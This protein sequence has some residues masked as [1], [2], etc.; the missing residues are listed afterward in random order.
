VQTDCASGLFCADGVCCN[1]ACTGT[2]QACSAA[3][4]GQGVDGVCGAVKAGDDPHNQCPASPAST[5]A[6]MGGCDGAGACAPWPDGTV[7]ST[8]KCANSTTQYNPRTCIGGTCSN[9]AVPQTACAPDACVGGASGACVT[10]CGTTPFTDTNC[11]I[12]NYCDGTGIGACKPKLTT[13]ACTNNDEC[14]S[15][16]CLGGACCASMCMFPGTPCGALFC[17]MT[18]G[19][20][21]YA[22]ALTNCGMGTCMS[23]KLQNLSVCDGAGQCRPTGG[24]NC[25]SSAACSPVGCTSCT[26]DMQCTQWGYC[27]GGTCVPRGQTGAACTASNQCLNGICSGT[28]CM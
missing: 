5:C 4:K 28:Q 20:C 24:Y 22:P 26:M 12:G 16:S 6:N 27:N 11:A 25:P 21:L 23:N 1:T 7:C 19:A 9:P 15:G 10:S 2:C 17:S 13:G 8:A 3:K 18:T 14:A